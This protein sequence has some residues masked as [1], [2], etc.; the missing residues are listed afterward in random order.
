MQLGVE[1]FA[2]WWDGAPEVTSAVN[3]AERQLSS[4]L[5]ASSVL[6]FPLF[7]YT[8]FGGLIVRRTLERFGLGHAIDHETINRLTSTAMDILVVAAITSLLA[9]DESFGRLANALW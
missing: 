1:W 6:D 5:S 8:L 3:D 2:Q 4:K 9:R 7:I